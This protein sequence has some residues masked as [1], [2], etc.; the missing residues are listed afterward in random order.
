MVCRGASVTNVITTVWSAMLRHLRPEARRPQRHE[1]REQA[2]RDDEGGVPQ[3]RP[4]LR[5]V[6]HDPIFV[7]HVVASTGR[8]NAS[9]LWLQRRASFPKTV[10]PSFGSRPNSSK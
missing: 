3:G 8:S 5:V 9:A 7:V 2:P 1:Q 6:G 4:R 10:H